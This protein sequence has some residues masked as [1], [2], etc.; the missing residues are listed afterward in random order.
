MSVSAF[1]VSA[2]AVFAGFY[3]RA[4]AFALVTLLVIAVSVTYMLLRGQPLGATAVDAVKLL[5]LMQ[6]SYVVGVFTAQLF[7][8][9]LRR[10]RADE[11]TMA[12]VEGEP[13][14]A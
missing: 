5:V 4:W 7:L 9:R 10:R 11:T 12:S 8:R 13:P 2:A 14:S 3:L 1:L 6:L